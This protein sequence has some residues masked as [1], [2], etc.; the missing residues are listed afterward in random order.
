VSSVIILIVDYF[1]TA[2]IY[3]YTI[4]YINFKLKCGGN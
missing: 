2:L 3:W 1:L 4:I